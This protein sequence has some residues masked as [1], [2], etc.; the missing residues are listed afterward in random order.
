MSLCPYLPLFIV[1]VFLSCFDGGGGNTSSRRYGAATE[2]DHLQL[3][4]R[5]RTVSLL[6]PRFHLNDCGKN[7]SN[8]RSSTTVGCIATLLSMTP[9]PLS[10]LR[11]I[12]APEVP[13]RR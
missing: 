12:G 7:T 1:P 13:L 11:T 4:L 3:P 10:L 5:R 6:A 8:L 9:H 2:D